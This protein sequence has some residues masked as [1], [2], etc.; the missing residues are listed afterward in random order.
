MKFSKRQIEDLVAEIVN[1]LPLPD[2]N[3]EQVSDAELSLLKDSIRNGLVSAFGQMF[4]VQN[5]VVCSLKNNVEVVDEKAATQCSSCK[6]YFCDK[7]KLKNCPE[8]GR[9]L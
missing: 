9:T 5:K 4:W 7:H 8:C 2:Y 1:D 6:K 3:A